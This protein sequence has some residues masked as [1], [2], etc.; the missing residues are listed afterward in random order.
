MN[1]FPFLLQKVDG[2]MLLSLAEDRLL[3]LTGLKVESSLKIFDLI[4]Q[5]EPINTNTNG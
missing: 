4:S 2:P 5:L 3:Q 1:F